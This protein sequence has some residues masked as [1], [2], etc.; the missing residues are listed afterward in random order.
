MAEIYGGFSDD[1]VLPGTPKSEKKVL[2]W[3]KRGGT[4]LLIKSMPFL[5]VAT[6]S[7]LLYLLC[8]KLGSMD[9]FQSLL[10]KIGC[11][12]GS[13]VLLK[14]G[15]GWL[16]FV[17]FLSAFGI[18]DGTIMHMMGENSKRWGSGQG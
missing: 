10:F 16:L 17:F 6:I 3:G 14:R 1:P 9:F 13:R 15:L 2:L 11:S 18:F 12:L 5:F 7:S 8:L 4:L